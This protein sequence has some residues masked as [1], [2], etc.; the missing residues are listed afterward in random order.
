MPGIKAEKLPRKDKRGR[1]S[2]PCR[3]WGGFDK[4][5]HIV[6]TICKRGCNISGESVQACR[7]TEHTKNCPF[8]KHWLSTSKKFNYFQDQSN[9]ILDAFDP[10][11][12]HWPSLRIPSWL[13]VA[14]FFF[15]YK[16]KAYLRFYWSCFVILM[17]NL[18]F[19]ERY[20]KFYGRIEWLVFFHSHRTNTPYTKSWV[21]AFL[22]FLVPY[23]LDI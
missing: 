4:A 22:A 2:G 11:D 23:V 15:L 20:H 10:P 7:R 13:P 17:Q 1:R 16:I 9:T 5:R 3:I 6:S 12:D 21:Y 19:L 18:K 8:D 14:F